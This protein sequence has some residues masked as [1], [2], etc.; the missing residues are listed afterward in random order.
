[1]GNKYVTK[2]KGSYCGRDIVYEGP[3]E[4]SLCDECYEK[5]EKTSNE[6]FDRGTDM[7]LHG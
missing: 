7:Y 6:S 4:P 2:C 5:Q 3:V 1:M